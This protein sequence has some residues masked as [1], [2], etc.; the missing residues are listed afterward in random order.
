MRKSCDVLSFCKYFEI[1]PKKNEMNFL[2][3]KGEDCKQMSCT[4][5]HKATKTIKE[6]YEAEEDKYGDIEGEDGAMSHFECMELRDPLLK[7][8]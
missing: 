6:G 7:F 3:C 8:E 1:W 5:C 2:F 4:V